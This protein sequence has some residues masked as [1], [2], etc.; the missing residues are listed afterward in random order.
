MENQVNTNKVIIQSLDLTI[1]KIR[2]KRN[3]LF[4]QTAFLSDEINEKKNIK[5]TCEWFNA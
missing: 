1:L 4:L 5:N 2:P 3:G